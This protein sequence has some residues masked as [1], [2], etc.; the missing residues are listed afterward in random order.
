MDNVR[1]FFRFN[2]N[3]ASVDCVDRSIDRRSERCGIIDRSTKQARRWGLSLASPSRST[4]ASESESELAC[5]LGHPSC[6]HASIVVCCGW[7]DAS[8]PFDRSCAGQTDGWCAA[9][10]FLNSGCGRCFYGFTCRI[11]AK[12]Q[13]ECTHQRR[14]IPDPLA[15]LT[16][17]ASHS[18]TATPPTRP[19]PTG[20][21]PH[22][23][24]VRPP[25]RSV[26]PLCLSVC[27]A[28]AWW[29]ALHAGSAFGG[30]REL[31]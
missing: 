23:H 2:Q 1:S 14:M 12:T 13:C 5:R 6:C 17:A 30:G 28:V 7:M 29:C 20:T 18:F 25:A 4:Q 24:H 27:D 21:S 9:L 3:C 31:P 8:P 15:W 16:P 11:R 26:S 10:L 19:H 22:T